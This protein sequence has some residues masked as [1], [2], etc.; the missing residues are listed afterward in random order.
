[1]LLIIEVVLVIAAWRRGWKGWAFLPLGAAFGLGFL[2][3]LVTG[4]TGASID[5]ISGFAL[6]FDIACIG[7][8]IGMVI[9]P[10]VSQ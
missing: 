1:M 7:A 3:S 10:R 4:S 2:L 5:A 9:K 8:L 6:V